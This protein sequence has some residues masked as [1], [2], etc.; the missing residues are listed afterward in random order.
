MINRFKIGIGYD[1]H[2]LEENRDLIIGGVKIPYEKGLLGHSD[3]DVLIHAIIDAL[4]GAAGMPDIG[5]IFPDTDEKFKDAN[6]IE[7]LKNVYS[8]IKD[9]GY[10]INNIDSNIIAQAPKMMKYI[11]IMK[12]ITNMN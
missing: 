8:K 2:R 12:N 9:K 10:K 6:S 11:P 5:T 7:L 1:I 3:A 4:L